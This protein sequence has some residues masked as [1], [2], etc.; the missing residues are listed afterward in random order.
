MK[1]L[2][3]LIL[4]IFCISSCSLIQKT[5]NTTSV[6]DNVLRD[7]VLCQVANDHNV[8]IEKVGKLIKLANALAITT[9]V[10]TAKQALEEV[11]DIRNK[12]DNNITYDFVA[13]QLKDL[14]T[15][16]PM[17]FIIMSDYISDLKM[18]TIISEFD[19]NILK[20]WLDSIIAD[21]NFLI[22]IQS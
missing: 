17:I 12:L 1:K 21:M 8:S 4:T 5:P 18:P 3:I 15:K 10:Y 11:K 14:Y 20:S 2:F 22:V 16:Y 19:K 9:D 13:N 7:S 6:C